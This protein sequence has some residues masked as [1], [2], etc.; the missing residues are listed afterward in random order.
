MNSTLNKIIA[1]A[2]FKLS[3]SNNS[4]CKIAVCFLLS[5]FLA[6]PIQTLATDELVTIQGTYYEK[7][8]SPIMAFDGEMHGL[9]T[10]QITIQKPF[11][12]VKYQDASALAN[13]QVLYSGAEASFDGTNIYVNHDVNPLILTQ[14]AA[15]KSNADFQGAND[16]SDLCR[17]MAQIYNGSYP[18]TIEPFIHNFWLAFLA[19]SALTNSSGTAKPVLATDLSMFYDTNYVCDYRW[20]IKD[21]SNG[22]R[23]LIFRSNGRWFQRDRL[24]NGRL[25]FVTLGKPYDKGFTLIDGAWHEATNL[26]GISLPLNYELKAYLP[27]PNAH[28]SNDL[29]S[30]Y[31][32]GCIVTNVSLASAAIEFPVPSETSFVTDH[33]FISDGYPNVTYYVTNAWLNLPSDYLTEALAR[34]PKMSLESASLLQLGFNPS[35]TVVGISKQTIVRILFLILLGIPL[36]FLLWRGIHKKHT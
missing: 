6:Y 25:G 28:D 18:P 17:R 7:N 9:G 10:F 32:F 33:R 24:K 14:N 5:W 12:I 26:A 34:A 4:I 20:E 19:E 11:W 3:A 30:W 29:T 35:L 15:H 13:G 31:R 16:T 8:D 2:P 22:S 23:N 36:S 27:K 21:G 1:T